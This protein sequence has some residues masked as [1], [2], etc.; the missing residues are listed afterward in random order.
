[1]KNISLIVIIDNDV[2]ICVFPA[3]DSTLMLLVSSFIKD[4]NGSRIPKIYEDAQNYGFKFLSY[5]DVCFLS[6]PL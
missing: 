5:G 1:M 3:P 6:R 4:V 2:I